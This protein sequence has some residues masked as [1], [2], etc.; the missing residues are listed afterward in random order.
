[1]L[2]LMLMLRLCGRYGIHKS[3]FLGPLSLW[4]NSLGWMD[5]WM[6]RMR[7]MRWMVLAGYGKVCMYWHSV[8]S[9]IVYSRYVQ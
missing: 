4:E 9:Y 8:S 3:E 7:R 1:M 2:M 6:R 5:G